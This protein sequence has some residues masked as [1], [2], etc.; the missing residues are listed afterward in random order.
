M[1]QTLQLIR[2]IMIKTQRRCLVQRDQ[3]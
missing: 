2:D 3:S 1:H